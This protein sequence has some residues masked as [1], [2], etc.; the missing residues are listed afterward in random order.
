[1]AEIIQFPGLPPRGGPH[2]DGAEPA[3]ERTD[4]T[5]DVILGDF[6]PKGTEEVREAT[7]E[8]VLK[9]ADAEE[10]RLREAD[11]PP[12][13][14]K[15]LEIINRGLP[16]VIIG[17]RPTTSGADF[18]TAAF[19]GANPADLRNAAPHLHKVLDGLLSRKGLV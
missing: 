11:L 12:D 3:P 6:R 9:A 19:A 18:L 8:E 7:M 17:I 15:T 14:M 2:G 5:T 16:F 4:G 1:M 10:Q 13:L